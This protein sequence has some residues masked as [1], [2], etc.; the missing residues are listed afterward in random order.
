[1]LSGR[2]RRIGHQLN[3][4][5]TIRVGRKKTRVESP[6]DLTQRR[7]RPV[8]LPDAPRA[9]L[10]VRDVLSV[11][12]VAAASAADGGADRRSVAGG[13]PGEVIRVIA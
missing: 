1:M 6:P 12:A 2:E 13:R 5:N 8:V 10:P 11:R 9:P 3:T 7:T 4:A